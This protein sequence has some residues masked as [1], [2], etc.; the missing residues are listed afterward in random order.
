MIST[1]QLAEHGSDHSASLRQYAQPE[2]A[3]QG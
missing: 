2:L 3:L 1:G